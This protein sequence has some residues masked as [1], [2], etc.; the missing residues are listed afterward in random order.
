MEHTTRFRLGVAAAAL[1]GC[2]VG[3]VAFGPAFAGALQEDDGSTTT[4]E[5]PAEEGATT[6]EGERCGPRRGLF[7]LGLETAAEAIGIEPAALREALADDQ[8]I[9]EVAEANGVDPATVVAALV[10]EAQER[11]AQAVADGHITQEE[12]DE[13]AA[14][15]EERMTDLVNGELEFPRHRPGRFGPGEAPDAD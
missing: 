6:E 13:R 1:A 5:A 2:A 14:T 9:A 3:G 11:L 12:A 10:A 8:T 7:R 15:L 4:T